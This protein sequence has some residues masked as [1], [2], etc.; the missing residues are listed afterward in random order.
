[1][2][3]THHSYTLDGLII[4]VMICQCLDQP[5]NI[6]F[7]HVLKLLF[8]FTSWPCS[9]VLCFE[10]SSVAFTVYPLGAYIWNNIFVSK[11]KGL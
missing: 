4:S 5:V 1:M 7:D 10:L 9:I 3:G 6:K 8:I 2:K 11:Q